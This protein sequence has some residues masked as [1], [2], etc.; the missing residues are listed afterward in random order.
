LHSLNKLKRLPNTTLV[1]CPHEKTK[2]NEA[3]ARTVEPITD[4]LIQYEAWVEQQRNDNLPTLPTT[5]EKEKNIN[6]FLRS[7][8]LSVKRAAESF[9]SS[10]LDDDAAVFAAVRRY[11]DEF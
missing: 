7:H 10:R 9:S 11:K 8:E 1:Y 5:L 3:F 6:P 2:P 4:A